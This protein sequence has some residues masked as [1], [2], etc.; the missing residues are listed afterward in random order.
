M[1]SFSDLPHII[2]QNSF[3]NV[4]ISKNNIAMFCLILQ[5]VFFLYSPSLSHP[6]ILKNIFKL[7]W[8]QKQD[9]VLYSS[10]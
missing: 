7:F 9:G 4:H 6:F 8:L 3:F 10:L 2:T 1:T 5:V